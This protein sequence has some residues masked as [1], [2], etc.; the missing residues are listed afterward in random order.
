MVVVPTDGHVTLEYRFAAA[1]VMGWVLTLAGLGLVVFFRRQGT[2]DLEPDWEEPP[3]VPAER[4][5]EPAPVAAAK[6]TAPR[7]ASVRGRVD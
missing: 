6:V 1:D 5:R 4:R 3:P 7:P 2:Q